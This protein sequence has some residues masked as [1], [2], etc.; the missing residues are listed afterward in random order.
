MVDRE[1]GPLR[2]VVFERVRDEVYLAIRMN[3]LKP[4]FAQLA[5][6]LLRRVVRQEDDQ[7]ID[8]SPRRVDQVLVAAVRR[9]EL[10]DDEA[11]RRV[12]S[13]SFCRACHVAC[14]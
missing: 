3:R 10:A 9:V 11:E 12:A 7:A 14:H 2:A 13:A 8:L 4:L 5:R 1:A 6:N